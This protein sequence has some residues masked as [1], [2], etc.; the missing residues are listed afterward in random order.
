[1]R[2]AQTFG[3]QVVLLDIGLPGID[4]H[5]VARRLRDLPATSAALLIAM[6]GYGQP[7]DRQR[8]LDAGFDHHLVKPATPE[9]VRALIADDRRSLN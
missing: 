6:S 7:E 2:F 3:P 1:V 5:E 8:S 9:R 4:G